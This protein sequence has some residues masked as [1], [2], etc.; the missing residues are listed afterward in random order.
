MITT[1][2]KI[3]TDIILGHLLGA[4]KN[5]ASAEKVDVKGLI[6]LSRFILHL[7]KKMDGEVI[8][9]S[10]EEEKEQQKDLQADA[11]ANG[12]SPS[13]GHAG[14]QPSAGDVFYTF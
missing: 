8:Y 7:L 6:L 11:P 2:R 4:Q 1:S 14:L 13:T 9:L 3:F 5:M 12:R 10:S